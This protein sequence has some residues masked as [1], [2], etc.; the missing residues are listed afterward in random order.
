[1]RSLRIAVIVFAIFAAAS[2]L[3]PQ[4]RVFMLPDP[5]GTFVHQVQVGPNFNLPG[6]VTLN[7]DGSLSVGSSGM[8]GG[9]PGATTRVSN[10]LGVWKITGRRSVGATSFMFVFDSNGLLIGYQRDRCSL[11][12]NRDFNAYQGTE[13]METMSCSSPFTCPDP[14]DPATVWTPLPGMPPSGFPVTGKRVQWLPV[15]PLNP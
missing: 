5:W 2:C 11:N 10:I 8:F 4:D 13:F 1:M 6:L 7:I 15:G 14:L 3:R 9:T 12:F